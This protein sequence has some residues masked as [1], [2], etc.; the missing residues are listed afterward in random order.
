MALIHDAALRPTKLELLA[1]WLPGQ[2]WF[3]GD[4]STLV[5]VASFRYDD[6]AGEVGIE[7]LLVRVDG[8]PVLQVPLTYRAAPLPGAALIGTM[9][10]SVLGQRWAY[11]ACTDPV[12]VAALAGALLA[13][14]PQAAQVREIDGELVALPESVAV[15]GSGEPGTPVPVIDAVSAST[16]DG[17]TTVSAGA[18]TLSVHRLP[19]AAAVVVPHSLTA[20]TGES[21]TPLLLATVG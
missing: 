6:P 7:T 1:T 10:H 20:T 13:G 21:G 12:Y 3:S 8:G 9:D 18:L 5:R 2:P 19:Q 11:D 15:T 4:A 17:V 14:A 16:V